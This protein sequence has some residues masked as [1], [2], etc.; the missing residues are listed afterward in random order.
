MKT[1]AIIFC[2]AIAIYAL[3]GLG[4]AIWFLL[5]GGG[6]RSLKWI[7]IWPVL[8]LFWLFGNVQ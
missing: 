2:I 1:L 3:V 5:H 4:F 6:A 7:L 8:V